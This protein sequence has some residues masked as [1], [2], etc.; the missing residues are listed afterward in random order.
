MRL[1]SDGLDSQAGNFESIV[2]AT[3]TTIIRTFTESHKIIEVGRDLWRLSSPAALFKAGS[4]RPD[5]PGHHPVGFRVCPRKKSP[6]LNVYMKFLVFH[7]LM[8]FQWAAVRK[9]LSVIFTFFHQVF[10][11]IDKMPL[12]LPLHQ[13]TQSQLSQPPLLSLHHLPGPSLHPFQYIHVWLVL[14]SPALQPR[15]Q[16]C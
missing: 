13:A 11:C 1:Q 2:I 5:C 10:V 16:R 3:G 14:G 12:E 9:A 6:L 7:C 4:A 15:P 8:S